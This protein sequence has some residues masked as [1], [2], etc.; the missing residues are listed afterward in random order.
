MGVLACRFALLSG[1]DEMRVR[2]LHVRFMPHAT[3][4]FLAA[5]ACTIAAVGALA[6]TGSSASAS[7]AGGFFPSPLA[8]S[9]PAI[10]APADVIVGEADDH[11]DLKVALSDQGTNTVTVHYAT[12]DSSALGSTACN[13]DYV[14]AAGTLTFMPGETSKTV[15]V[16]ILDC[17]PASGLKAFTFNLSTAT[18]GVITRA[19]S[20][21]SI[22]DNDTIVA[23]PRLF[24]RDAVVDERDGFALVSVL[25]GGTGGQASNSTVTVD[26]PL[27]NGK[28][29][30]GSDYTAVSGTLSF[31]PGE[32]AKTISVPITDDATAEGQERFFLNLSN[33]NNA[34]ISDDSGSILIGA[35]DTAASSQPAAFAPADAIVGEG[36]GYVDLMVR[37]S[38]PGSNPVSVHYATAD[39]SALGSTACNYDYVPASDRKSVV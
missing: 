14:S 3:A 30:A 39:S 7:S 38:Q 15:P 2:R 1:R 21:V 16:Q 26:Y 27:P 4:S 22:V 32:T 17:A 12:A 23:T 5:A 29:T 20:R 24:V 34:T 28:S 18:N 36:D 19:S 10:L 13:Y 35:S 25:L 9:N 31:A 37:L 8:S 33:P 11:V 6:L